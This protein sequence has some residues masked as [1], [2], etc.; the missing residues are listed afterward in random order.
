VYVYMG[1]DAVDWQVDVLNA[2]WQIVL[3]NVLPS[4]LVSELRSPC[5][6][7]RLSVRLAEKPLPVMVTVWPPEGGVEVVVE[8]RISKALVTWGSST[9]HEELTDQTAARGAD[10]R[11][12]G[13]DGDHVH[14][15]G[16]LPHTHIHT[17]RRVFESLMGRVRQDIQPSH[18]RGE[19]HVCPTTT[20]HRPATHSAHAMPLHPPLR[21]RVPCRCPPALV[22]AQPSQCSCSGPPAPREACNKPG[23]CMRRSGD[24]TAASPQHTHTWRVTGHR[25]ALTVTPRVGHNWVSVVL[26]LITKI[27]KVAAD[28]DVE[29]GGVCSAEVT[30]KERAMK[31]WGSLGGVVRQ[32][33]PRCAI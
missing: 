13:V 32:R 15:A 33:Q 18:A 27:A 3:L 21:C 14:L 9:V 1:G 12:L 6:R 8:P 23:L 5:S 19:D 17:C 31:R 26:P 24:E 4:R 30:C 22:L 11:D 7:M 16:C 2:P 25:V 20:A 29:V 28:R 10:G